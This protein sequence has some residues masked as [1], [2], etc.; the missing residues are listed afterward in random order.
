MHRNDAEICKATHWGCTLVNSGNPSPMHFIDA[1]TETH[2]FNCTIVIDD[3]LC[4]VRDH[5]ASESSFSVS[6]G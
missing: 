5:G 3:V 4:Y 2:A 1:A 6:I